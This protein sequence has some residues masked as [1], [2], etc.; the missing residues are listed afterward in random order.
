MSP[1]QQI[2][3]EM[4]GTEASEACLTSA[5]DAVSRHVAGPHLG[6]QEYAIALTCDYAADEFLGTVH[7]RRVDQRHPKRKARAQRFLFIS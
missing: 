3:I 4:I 7:F 2:E 6:D 1:V 5:R